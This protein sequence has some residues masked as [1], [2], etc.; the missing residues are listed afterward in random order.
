VSERI[1]AF[2]ICTIL[3]NALD[4]AIEACRGAEDGTDRN[5]T[6]KCVL[7]NDTQ[8]ISISNPSRGADP[9]LKTT[10]EDKE[11]HG[12]GLNNIRRTVEGMGGT[13]E[14]TQNGSEFL[15][16]IMFTEPDTH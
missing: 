1:S 16:D 13:M 5:I 14:I 15:L 3:S 8:V 9:Q 12:F 6:V 7:K 10:K 4:N 2:D 11:L